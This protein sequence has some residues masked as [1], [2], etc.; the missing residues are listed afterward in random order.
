MKNKYNFE[1]LEKKE[2]YSGRDK[3]ELFFSMLSLTKSGSSIYLMDTFNELES[4]L[5][6]ETF[7]IAHNLVSRKGKQVYFNGEIVMASRS[8]LIEFLKKSLEINDLRD[9]LISPIF[10]DS[11]HYVVFIN[12]ESFYYCM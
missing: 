11:P 10:D 2:I 9:F 6:D 5:T 3:S 1:L 8:C 4:K 12:D 7:Y